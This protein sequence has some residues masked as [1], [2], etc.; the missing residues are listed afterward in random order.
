M[1]DLSVGTE[2][3]KERKTGTERERESRRTPQTRV[4]AP[5]RARVLLPRVY[6]VGKF[7]CDETVQQ[8]KEEE[9]QKERMN[10]TGGWTP[11]SGAKNLGFFP[12]RTSNESIYFIPKGFATKVFFASE[13][14]AMVQ[15]GE[16]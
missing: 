8:P 7:P 14:R 13:K 10:G 6:R 12:K 15:I 5:S 11:H 1:P 16:H 2:R 9:R 4:L 3:E